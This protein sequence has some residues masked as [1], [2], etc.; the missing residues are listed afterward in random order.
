MKNNRLII[1][2]VCL[3]LVVSLLCGCTGGSVTPTTT[4]TT[5]KVDI[6]DSLGNVDT[7]IDDNDKNSDYDQTGAKKIT[8]SG[9]S[10]SVKG[11]GVAAQGSTVRISAD[12]T[13]VV[14]GASNDGYII[15]EA[16]KAEVK[17]V[18][19]GVN[20]THTD[21]PAILVKNAKKVTFTIADGTNNVLSDGSSY[22]LYEGNA[23]V[24]GA[25]FAKADLV[26]NGNGTLTV[27]GNNAH[28]IVSKD[29]LTITG[30]NIIVNSKNAGIY[31][32]DFLKIVDAN[33]TIKAGTDGLKADNIDD[34]SAGYIY[35][36]SGI[37]NIN[38][39]NDAI[40]S[41]SVVSIDNG[42]FNIKTTSTLSTA[43]AKGVKG[44]TG[45]AISGGT[46]VIDAADDGIHSDGDVLVAGGNIS[47]KSA[48][49]GVHANDNLEI[50]GGELVIEKSYEGLEAT[51]IAISNGKVII[52]AT[53][54]G[55][56]ASGGN[57]E[58]TTTGGRPGD[59]FESTTGSITISGGYVI[60]HAEGDGVDA[61]GTLTIS[62]GVVLVDG[63]SRGGNGSLDYNSTASISGGVFIA[64]G[65][66]DM[67]QNFKDAT[68]GSILTTNSSSFSAGTVISVCDANGNVI[69]AFRSTKTFNC[70]TVSAPELKQGETYTFY[71][72]ASVSGLDENGFAHNTTQSGGTSWQTVTL[73]SLI[74]GQGSSMPG[75]GGG[76]PGGTRP[77]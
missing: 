38:S 52:N 64:L 40:Q 63:P 50:T 56:N 32:K 67:A 35:I 20:L 2:I 60:V 18:L 29:A 69:V 5:T 76:F 48:D 33:V 16:S 71:K 9:D 45:V 36:Q 19:N 1:I 25:I 55:M 21:G 44:V 73:S 46:F 26:F 65:T 13:Y 51:D 28:G 72:N 37:F 3:S 43:S 49:D 57:D 30:G 68:Q 34:A 62:G 22:S 53:D 66:S 39:A 15:I 27:N 74:S 61:N 6:Q 41:S 17:L 42:T 58:N 75:G 24:D 14:S 31:G 4:T 12:G 11:T 23:V 59:M 7:D 70:V 10:A 47:I 77:R 8:F 54:D